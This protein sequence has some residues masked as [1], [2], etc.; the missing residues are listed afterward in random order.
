MNKG[1]G[2]EISVSVFMIFF[3]FLFFKFHT[4]QEAGEVDQLVYSVLFDSGI[5]FYINFW[6]V[7]IPYESV[8]SLSVEKMLMFPL[9]LSSSFEKKV[10]YLF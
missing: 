10:E 7:F 8:F 1:N 9:T 2:P 6:V 4:L 5:F 3:L